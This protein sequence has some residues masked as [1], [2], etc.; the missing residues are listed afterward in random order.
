[1]PPGRLLTDCYCNPIGPEG[2]AHFAFLF[3]TELVK[4]GRTDY[5]D[6]RFTRKADGASVIA[7][8]K[9]SLNPDKTEFAAAY[10]KHAGKLAKLRSK[11]IS[12]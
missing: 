2:L 9:T 6:Y 12:T 4:K 7:F 10:N 5:H 3:E 8:L 11:L 1:M